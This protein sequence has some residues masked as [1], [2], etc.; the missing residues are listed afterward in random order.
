MPESTEVI[1]QILNNLSDEELQALLTPTNL[2]PLQLDFLSLHNKNNHLPFPMMHRLV[3]LGY[4]PSKFSSLS[5]DKSL[6]CPSCIFGKMKRRSWRSRGPPGKI[7]KTTDTRPGS[8]VC[9]DQM[10]SKQ[11][12]LIPRL[13]GNHSRDRIFC[14]TVSSARTTA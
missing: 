4:L 7:L 8:T 12:G 14:I 13:Q 9:V 2:S 5:S 3:K 11:P 1:K 10:I 6:I